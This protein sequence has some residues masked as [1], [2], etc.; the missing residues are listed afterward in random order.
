MLGQ[1]ER[2]LSQKPKTEF[3]NRVYIRSTP[4]LQNINQQFRENNKNRKKNGNFLRKNKWNGKSN[5]HLITFSRRL[6]IKRERWLCRVGQSV[7]VELQK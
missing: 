1:G 5:R 2:I 6:L 7:K 4:K 3:P